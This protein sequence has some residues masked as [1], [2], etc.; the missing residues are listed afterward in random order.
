MFYYKILKAYGRIV[1]YSAI[2]TVSINLSISHDILINE[3]EK[4]YNKYMLNTVYK[5]VFYSTMIPYTI[6]KIMTRKKFVDEF[7]NPYKTI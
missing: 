6:F 1:T 3:K 2:S 7:F 4:N 5:C